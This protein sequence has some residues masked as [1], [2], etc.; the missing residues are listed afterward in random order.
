[1]NDQPALRRVTMDVFSAEPDRYQLRSG[2]E[3]DA[4]DCPYG[5]RYQWIGYDTVAQQYVRFSESVFKKL[6][7]TIE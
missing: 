5:N 4:P 7:C 3:P 2:H 1:M 6:V